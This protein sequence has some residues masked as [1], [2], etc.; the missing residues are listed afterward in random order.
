MYL[1]VKD[2][3]V[4]LLKRVSRTVSFYV[5]KLILITH[6]NVHFLKHLNLNDSVYT[7]KLILLR[8]QK[9]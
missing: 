7:E 4:T 5:F 6:F 9:F 2:T 3:L 1:N 8:D